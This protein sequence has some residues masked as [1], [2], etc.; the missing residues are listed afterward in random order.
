MTHCI[1]YPLATKQPDRISL[2][3][4]SDLHFASERSVDDPKGFWAA[5]ENVVQ[6]WAELGKNI[7]LIAVTGD[8]LENG[9]WRQG[10]RLKTLDRVKKNLHK[11]CGGCN[12]D[13]KTG[14][15]V[16]P[17]NHDYKW[18]GVIRNTLGRQVFDAEFADYSQDRLFATTDGW[19]LFVACFDSN[20]VGGVADLARGAVDPLEARHRM[21]G[22]NDR[23][24]RTNNLTKVALVHHHPLPV[25]SSESLQ[26]EGL[27]E[28]VTGR[29]WVGAPEHMVFRNAGTFLE[30]LLLHGFR[31]VLH[32]HLH[33]R[34]YLRLSRRVPPQEEL[35]EVF[36]GA[37][38]GAPPRNGQHGFHLLTIH[39]DGRLK[40][41]HYDFERQGGARGVQVHLETAGYSALR[42][43]RRGIQ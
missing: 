41:T 27:L 13:P 14:L 39:R 1:E 37:S 11:L 33:Y 23:L 8:L 29:Q 36:S 22:Y 17:G 28:E 42:R 5:F 9:Q 15:F 2:L 34:G 6:E 26:P 20:R 40:S 24:A 30:L 19:H 16:I 4:I 3:H 43:R 32:G 35:L 10:H 18:K 31:A 25:A 38:L 21:L 7:D 12:I